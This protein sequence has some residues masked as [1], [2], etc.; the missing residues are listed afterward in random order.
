[1]YNVKGG[2]THLAIVAWGIK[3]K[4]E[5]GEYTL[6]LKA[7]HDGTPEGQPLKVRNL[8]VYAKRFNLDI[9]YTLTAIAEKGSLNPFAKYPE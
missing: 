5:P 1:L 9:E 8:D 2:Y 7:Q 4:L 3:V 6:I